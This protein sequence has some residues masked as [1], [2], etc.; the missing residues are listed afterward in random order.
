MAD[1]DV[2][3]GKGIIGHDPA[4]RSTDGN[5]FRFTLVGAPVRSGCHDGTGSPK[6]SL[7]DESTGRDLRV[8]S[9]ALAVETLHSH[10]DGHV[11]GSGEIAAVRGQA[12]HGLSALEP[13]STSSCACSEPCGKARS[14]PSSQQLSSSATAAV[15]PPRSSPISAQPT[16]RSSSSSASGPAVSSDQSVQ[17]TSPSESTGADTSDPEPVSDAPATPGR[18][19]A[20]TTTA[21]TASA[22]AS[23]SRAQVS[24]LSASSSGE[25]C[26]VQAAIAELSLPSESDQPGW[27]NVAAESSSGHK[28]EGSSGT[29]PIAV[30]RPSERTRVRGRGSSSAQASSFED[31]LAADLHEA[32]AHEKQR[33]PADDRCRR[34]SFRGERLQ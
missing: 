31:L 8:L 24:S 28:Y 11:P 22:S 12:A 14:E 15:A 32:A 13:A 5:G 9:H 7:I 16:G 18:S 23:A 25:G 21:A 30:E 19:T 2:L 33:Q 4:S 29:V 27:S 3:V 6:T 34:E 17:P 1:V 10:S 20:T 26:A